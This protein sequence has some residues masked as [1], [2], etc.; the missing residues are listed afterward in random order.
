MPNDISLKD[1]QEE[2]IEQIRTWRNMPEISEYMYT[3]EIITAEQQKLWYENLKISKSQKAWIIEYNGKK[4]GVA[5][6]Y[7]IKEKFKTTYWA[8]YLGDSS[9]RGAGIGAKVEYNM[10][11]YVFEEMKFNKLLC[12][13]FVWNQQVISMHEK[14]GFRRESYFREHIIKDKK[15]YDVIGLALLKNEWNTIKDTMYAKLYGRPTG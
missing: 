14:F 5:S 6:L 13:V 10:C 12:E 9:V 3:N 11:R 4:L 15:T 8:F 1:I 2:D 7:D